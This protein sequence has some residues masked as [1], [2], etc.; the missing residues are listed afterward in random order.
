M[1][2][3]GMAELCEVEH[4]VIIASRLAAEAVVVD[5]RSTDVRG[6]L[7]H[8]YPC[9]EHWHVGH[10]QPPGR[11]PRP[12]TRPREVPP[13]LTYNPEV[14]EQWLALLEREDDHAEAV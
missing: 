13:P 4:K 10:D 9:G 5:M 1:T 3:P 12:G 7:L 11:K 2:M 14:P 6:D 8:P